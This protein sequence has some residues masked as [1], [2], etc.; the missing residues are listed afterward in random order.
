[1]KPFIWMRIVSGG[2][3]DYCEPLKTLA[4][5]EALEETGFVVDLLVQFN[6]YLYPDRDSL[7]HSISTVFVGQATGEAQAGSDDQKAGL[8]TKNTLSTLLVFDHVLIFKDYFN[9]GIMAG[10]RT[11]KTIK[12][13]SKY[14]KINADSKFYSS[15]EHGFR[16]FLGL[17]WF[18]ELYRLQKVQPGYM[19]LS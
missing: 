17:A 10:C 15:W 7:Q 16:A 9:C 6:T 2:F 4:R 8:F 18:R 1:M 14:E 3:V 19:E 11:A 12:K 13:L 5:R